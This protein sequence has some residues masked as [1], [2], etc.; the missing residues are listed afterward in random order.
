MAD[1]VNDQKS[2]IN[3]CSLCTVYEHNSVWYEPYEAAEF[4]NIEE[5]CYMNSWAEVSET[6]DAQR[7]CMK[8]QTY[9]ILFNIKWTYENMN[10]FTRTHNKGTPSVSSNYCGAQQHKLNI[11]VRTTQQHLRDFL[12]ERDKWWAGRWDG[13]KGRKQWQV[14]GLRAVINKGREWIANIN[15]LNWK[16]VFTDLFMHVNE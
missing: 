6:A 16:D 12:T 4:P 11:A 3:G 7:Q 15:G 13:W 8:L 10:Q 14:R 2:F 1:S 5:S 9:W